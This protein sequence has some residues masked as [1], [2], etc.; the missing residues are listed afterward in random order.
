MSAD[1]KLGEINVIV[2]AM[3]LLLDHPSRRLSQGGQRRALVHDFQDGLTLNWAGDYPGG[4]TIAGKLKAGDIHASSV[5]APHLS[6]TDLKTTGI[7]VGGVSIHNTASDSGGGVITKVHSHKLMIYTDT[8]KAETT[9]A[10]GLGG[11]QS[12]ETLDLV[13]ELRA[14]RKEVNELKAKVAALE[15]AG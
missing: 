4:V 14:L 2:E 10:I 9:S 7:N 6:S 1:I 12:K 5:D 15:A 13:A 8:I 11:M 3:D